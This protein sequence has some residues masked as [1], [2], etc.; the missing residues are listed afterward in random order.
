M[1]PTD[2]TIHSVSGDR[3]RAAGAVILRHGAHPPGTPPEAM[4]L[5][6]DSGRGP[7]LGKATIGMRALAQSLVRHLFITV[8]DTSHKWCAP[9]DSDHLATV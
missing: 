1:V 9:L 2:G 3:K 6:A 5:S 4:L 8:H 7:G